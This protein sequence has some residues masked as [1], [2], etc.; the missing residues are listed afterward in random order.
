V[1]A[2]VRTPVLDRLSFN[3]QFVVASSAILVMGM[4]TIGVWV[5]SAVEQAVIN[6][7]A[8]VTALYLDS[9][10]SPLV[11][12]LPKTGDLSPAQRSELDRLIT[13]TPLGK[14]VVSFKI[15]S[16]DGEIMYSPNPE[17]IG[18]TFAMEAHLQEAFRGEVVS[19]ISDLA[20]QENEYERSNWETLIETYAPVRSEGSGAV[21]AVSEFYQLPDALEGEIRTAQIRGWLI[22][23]VATLAMY[24]LLMGMVRRAS[25]TIRMQRSELLENLDELQEALHENQRLQAR[26]SKAAARTTTLN[27]RFLRRVSADIHDGPAQ[28]VSLALLRVEGIAERLDGNGYGSPEDVK[29]LRSALDSALTEL[30]AISHGLRAPNVEDLTPGE[31][32][33]RAVTDYERISGE[34][35]TFEDDGASVPGSPSVSITV[36][37]VIQESLANSFRHAGSVSRK[38]KVKST[39]WQVEVVISDTGSGFEPA[40]LS[41]GETLG[42]V[43]MRERV[44]LLGGTFE[45][46]SRRGEGTV[47]E[48]TLPL[49]TDE[50]DG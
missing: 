21:F 4:V 28:D 49:V 39:D 36:Y 17:L 5:S 43:G 48:T 19:E 14:Q 46:T 33:R 2:H 35:I 40:Q 41:S 44:E 45:V 50:S 3:R 30:R 29:R 47:V 24:L 37:R 1:E 7:T 6:R 13:G 26:V 42:L 8:G 12:D 32:A 16:P 34:S 23:G 38:V 27:E 20:E 10:V 11:Q 22:V 18:Q 31:A 25:N 9:F 15:W